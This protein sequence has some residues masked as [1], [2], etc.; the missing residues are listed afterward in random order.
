MDTVPARISYSYYKQAISMAIFSVNSFIEKRGKN[1][2]Q[3]G[4]VS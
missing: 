3:P 2:E 4:S 1:A